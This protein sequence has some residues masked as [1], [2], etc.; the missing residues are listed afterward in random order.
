M[1]SPAYGDAV[2]WLARNDECEEHDPIVIAGLTTVLLAA[3]LFRVEPLRLAEDI[4][5]ARHG[6]GRW[7]VPLEVR[8]SGSRCPD[9]L[10][11]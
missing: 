6:R 7:R 9:P 4:R 3:D 1:K 10:E 5:A 2:L 11:A 8:C